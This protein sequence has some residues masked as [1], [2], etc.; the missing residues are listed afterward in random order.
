MLDVPHIGLLN[1]LD[2][3]LNGNGAL[4]KSQFRI[5]HPPP[6]RRCGIGILISNVQPD[7]SSSNQDDLTVFESAMSGSRSWMMATGIIMILA[8]ADAII[9][10]MISSLA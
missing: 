4:Q 5:A 8:G 3:D 7:M 9:F 1:L 10:P 2:P 6:L